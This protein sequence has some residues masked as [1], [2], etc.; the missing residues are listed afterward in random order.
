[1]VHVFGEEGWGTRL[2]RV[3]SGGPSTVA[4]VSME[5]RDTWLQERVKD[6]GD[7]DAQRLATIRE[8]AN[9]CRLRVEQ[10]DPYTKEHS[11]RVATWSR[12]L[13][14]RLPTF[15]KDRKDRLE[16]T[17]L[18]HDYGKIDVRFEVL[19]KP[20]AL[21]PEEFAEIKMHPEFGARRLKPFDPWIAMEGVLYHHV[22]YEGGGYPETNLAGNEIPLEARIIAV[23]DVFDAVTSAR[24]YRQ[25]KSPEKALE[26]MKQ[27]AGKQLDPTLVQIFEDYYKMEK[28][29]KGYSVGAQTMMLL[30]TVDEEIRRAEEFLRRHVGDFDRDSPLAKIGNP[31]RFVMAAVD[32]LVSLS[33]NRETAERFVRYAYKMPLKET[34]E[35]ANID[36]GNEEFVKLLEQ[37]VGRNKGHK[38]ITLPLKEFKKEYLTLDIAVFNQKLWKAIGDGRKMVL[39]R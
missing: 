32:Y 1:M 35:R 10:H 15:D 17:A 4:R 25:A 18:V 30:A 6:L 13:A 33:V 29:D 31:E 3:P 26:I 27:V 5:A 28:A 12:I 8:I 36:L 39:L 20:G 23:C 21:S 19:N 7:K 14:N 37:T 2:P 16:I 22:R 9:M 34:F 24:C 11:V 38:Q